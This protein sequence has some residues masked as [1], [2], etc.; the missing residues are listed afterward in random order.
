[1]LTSCTIGLKEKD[2]ILATFCIDDG[3]FDC[4]GAI[5]YKYFF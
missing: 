2:G 1:M 5:L 4:A 3:Y